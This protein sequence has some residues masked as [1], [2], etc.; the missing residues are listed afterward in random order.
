MC[1][2][3][4]WKSKQK[5]LKQKIAC[6][7]LFVWVLLNYPQICL[8]ILQV[9]SIKYNLYTFSVVFL[10]AS[11]LSI[12]LLHDLPTMVSWYSQEIFKQHINEY[13]HAKFLSFSKDLGL[14]EF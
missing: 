6:N 8:G 1:Q 12:R 3:L 9:Q 14:L 5:P 7:F 11:L 13:L 4:I 10:F 2:I